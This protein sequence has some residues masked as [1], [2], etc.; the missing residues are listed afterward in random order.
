MIVIQEKYWRG[1]TKSQKRLQGIYYDHESEHL[2]VC[3]AESGEIIK[4]NPTTSISFLYF[5]CFG[6][7]NSYTEE[8]RCICDVP[9]PVQIIRSTTN[10]YLV[11][12]F[13]SIIYLI[14]KTGTIT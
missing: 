6:V 4:V 11:T 5:F 10:E 1:G 8:Y 3:D 7:S 12:S 9:G 14:S 2:L 13:D